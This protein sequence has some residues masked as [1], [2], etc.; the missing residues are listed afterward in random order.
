MNY[1]SILALLFKTKS[2]LHT[3][4]WIKSL[5]KNKVIDYNGNPIPWVCYPFIH[6]LET[7][8]SKNTKVFEF[9]SGASTL[10]FSQKINHVKSVEHNEDW[11][12]LVKKNILNNTNVDLTLKRNKKN[13][14]D[15]ISNGNDKYDLIFIDGVYRIEC[16]KRSLKYLSGKGVIVFDD[17]EREENREVYDIMKKQEFKALD[18]QGL[19]PNAILLSRT[20][21]FYRTNNIL[22]I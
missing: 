1:R 14:L 13:Y 17:M 22:N 16:L 3:S 2:Y 18:F 11:F 10:W 20:T 21:V 6:F 7:K 5:L 12:N 19:K 9:G 4:G 15:F 8:I